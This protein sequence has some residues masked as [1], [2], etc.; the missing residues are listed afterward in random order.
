ALVI[1]TS[2]LSTSA[3][4]G[5]GDVR[6]D[7][8]LISGALVDGVRVFKGVPFAAPPIGDLRWKEPKPVVAWSG[9]RK[10][11]VFGPACPQSPYP[12]ASMY[13]SS[14]EKM[15]EDCLYLNVWTTSGSGDK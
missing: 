12:A 13:Y 4:S 11:D 14:P 5:N 10:C 9:V 2:I 1:L 15:S 3:R 8:G 6:V 7:G